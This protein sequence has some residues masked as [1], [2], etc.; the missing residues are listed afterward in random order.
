MIDLHVH[1]LPGVDDGPKEWDKSLKMLQRAAQ[2]G[3]RGLV[4]TPHVM[5]GVY[6]NPMERVL[7]LTEELKER[8][9][10][11][12]VD[13]YAGSELTV[14]HETLAGLEGKRYCTIN[15][16][17]YVLLELPGHFSLDTVL[18]FIFSVTSGGKVPIIA[19]PERNPRIQ[20]DINILYELTRLGALLQITS[21]SLTGLFGGAVRKLTQDIVSRRLAHLIAS[22]AHN[23][24]NRA[25]LLSDGVKEA[26]KIIGGRAASTMVNDLPEKILNNQIFHVPEPVYPKKKFFFF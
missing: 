12:P 5:P 4:A 8:G 9:K 10:S 24:G 22:D 16:T 21:G 1:I 6:D 19:H 7:A 23:N 2:D 25:P 13:I 3:I 18:D 20:A 15:G 11:L 14:S 26:A 17:R